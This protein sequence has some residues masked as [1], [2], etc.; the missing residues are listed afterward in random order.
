[1]GKDLYENLVL[2]KEFFEKVNDILGYCIIDIMFEGIDEDL[3]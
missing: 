3:C 1:M 2:V